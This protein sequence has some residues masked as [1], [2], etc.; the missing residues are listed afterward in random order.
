MVIIQIL[1]QQ[2]YGVALVFWNE[3]SC[4]VP[5]PHANRWTNFKDWD[6]PWRKMMVGFML[7]LIRVEE[8]GGEEWGVQTW[9]GKMWDQPA[10][11]PHGGLW[12]VLL[13]NP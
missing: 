10:L 3:N 13:Y 5:F 7:H 1:L 4:V 2:R 8:I 12:S 9:G 6:S 11:G